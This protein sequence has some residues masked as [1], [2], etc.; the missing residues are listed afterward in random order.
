MFTEKTGRRE[1]IG[2]AVALA[3]AG[4]RTNGGGI[5]PED[6]RADMRRVVA[7]GRIDPDAAIIHHGWTGPAI[8]VDP[9]NDFAGVVLGSR[10]G[11]RDASMAARVKI[12]EHLSRLAV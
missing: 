1:F 10:W 3:S 2:G 12:L 8:A 11:D 4:C 9:E 7:D 6:I 5:W